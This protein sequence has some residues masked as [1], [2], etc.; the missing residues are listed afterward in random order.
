VIA[1]LVLLVSLLIIYLG[2][3]AEPFQDHNRIR[4]LHGTL[5]LKALAKAVERYKADCGD[6][7]AASD[8]LKA[9]VFNPGVKGWKGPYLQKDVPLDPWGRPYVYLC[10]NGSTTPE[11]VSYGAEGKPGGTSFDAD[12]STRNLHRSIP[13]S[14]SE[15]RARRVFVGSWIAA[16]C[17]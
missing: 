9:L 8:G 16:W 4:Y 11:I 17:C 6:Y 7:P 12:I 13:S 10:P 5:H 2:F 3:F 15:V 1:L 14:P